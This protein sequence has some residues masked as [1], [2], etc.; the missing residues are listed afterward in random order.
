MAGEVQ[1]PRAV[2]T[3]PARTDRRDHG[4][5]QRREIVPESTV[6]Q[7]GDYSAVV[8]RGRAVPSLFR[9]DSLLVRTLSEHS[10]PLVAERWATHRSQPA[11]DPF[12]RAALETLGAVLVLPIRRATILAA[13]VCLGEKRSGDVYTSTDL[14]LLTAVTDRISGELLRFDDAEVIRQGRTMQEA[15]RRY[16]PGSVAQQI[17]SGQP[18]E[19]AEREVTVLFVD[20]RGHTS[21]AESR[22]AA[23]VFSTINRFTETVSRVVSEHGGS[24]VEF[25]GDGMMAVFGAP[26]VLSQKER[27]AVEAGREV[28]DAV[29][30][31][32]P[33]P[34]GH[35]PLAVGVGIATGSCFVGNVQAVDHLIWTAIGNIPNRAARLQSLTRELDAAMVIDAA[36]Y[37]AARYVA[38]DFLKREGVPIRGLSEPLDIFLLESPAVTRV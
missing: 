19:S 12:D 32:A 18:L 1:W 16:V 4:E 33:E 35:V 13:F 9:A 21:Y 29:R 8:V 10:R 3:L 27:A 2:R 30:S 20:I 36:T 15:L 38:S 7:A 34:P 5:P 24:V 23:E 17:A 37:Q 28:F 25:S 11:L 22:R 14:A 31:L 6:D 26:E